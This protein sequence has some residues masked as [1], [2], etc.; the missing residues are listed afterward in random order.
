[1]TRLG[2]MLTGT[3]L[4]VGGQNNGISLTNAYNNY[5]IGEP[6]GGTGEN[7][8]VVNAAGKWVDVSCT[9]TFSFIMEFECPLGMIFGATSCIGTYVR[10]FVCLVVWL[11]V[12]WC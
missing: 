10:L 2:M 8:V 11:A 1:M 6:N 7:C 9:T 5:A 12:A 4:W 3:F